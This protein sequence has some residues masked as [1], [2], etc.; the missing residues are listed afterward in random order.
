V[1]AIIA[2]A[3][4]AALI[5]ITVLVTAATLTS[6]VESYRGLFLWAQEHGVHGVP[7]V[8]AGRLRWC[9][10]VQASSARAAADVAGQYSR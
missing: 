7:G 9:T 5:V 1:P 4:L 8:W 6:F 3:R 10:H 2:R